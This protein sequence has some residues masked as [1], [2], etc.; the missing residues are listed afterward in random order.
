MACSI[1]GCIQL[2]FCCVALKLQSFCVLSVQERGADMVF[3][4]VRFVLH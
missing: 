2:S 4:C 3:D 1:T